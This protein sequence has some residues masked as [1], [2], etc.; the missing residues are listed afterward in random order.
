MKRPSH[1]TI[2]TTFEQTDGDTVISEIEVTIRFR[3]QPESGD[4]WNEPIEPAWCEFHSLTHEPLA[5]W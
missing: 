5:D 4:N 1:H 2:K 3:Y